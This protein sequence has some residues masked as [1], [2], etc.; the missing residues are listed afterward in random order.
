[1]SKL[2]APVMKVL[3]GDVFTYL[4][5]MGPEFTTLEFGQGSPF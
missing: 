1:M 2:L 4:E 3:L 5:R